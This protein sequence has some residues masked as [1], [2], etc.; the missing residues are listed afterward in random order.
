MAI[1]LSVNHGVEGGSEDEQ[2]VQARARHR[3][4]LLAATLFSL[5]TPMLLAGDELGHQP[6]RQ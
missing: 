5:G 6:V 4:T 1:T 2:V 3:R